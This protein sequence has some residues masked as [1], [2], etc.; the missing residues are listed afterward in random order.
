MSRDS[1]YMI[2]YVDKI[3][4]PVHGFIDI[5]TV[6]QR[7]IALPIFR[8][9]QSIK[10]LSMT[11]WVFPGAEHTRYIHSLGVMYIADQM[12]IHLKGF[13]DEDRQLVRLAGLLHDIGHYPLSHVT[14]TAY[15]EQLMEYDGSLEAH[16]GSVRDKVEKLN[17]CKI[18]EYMESRYTDKMHHENIGATV[19]KTDK[20][21]QSIIN[22]ECPFIDTE[23]IC[24]IIVG[25]VDRNPNNSIFVQ[26][27]HSELDADGIDYIMRDAS[28]SGT[29]Y[30]SFSLGMLLRNLTLGSYKGTQIVGVRPKGVPIADQ[31][32]ISKYLSYTQVI[33]NKHVAILDLMIEKCTHALINHAHS[34]YPSTKDFMKWVKMHNDENDDYLL[35]TDV[36][37]WS[38]VT[39]VS[40]KTDYI[41]EEYVR[42]FVHNLIHYNEPCSID[43]Y[44]ITSG[45]MKKVQDE[46]MKSKPYREL[47]VNNNEILLFHERGFTKEIPEDKYKELLS[48]IWK[49]AERDD[50]FENSNTKRLQEGIA[51]IEGNNEPKLLVDDPRSL[52]YALWKDRT[53]ILRR[54]KCGS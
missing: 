29:S 2:E 35:F 17:E 16:N 36:F 54:Y 52:M 39:D 13:N 20:H 38:Q 42:R 15:R 12:L 30:G 47:N 32:L 49:N 18:P 48:N 25:D 26:L 6:E 33:F 14:E 21:I 34:E 8:R 51:V 40:R 3:L 37:F 45:D 7:L 28:F 50:L 43:E 1:G 46:I 5:T 27:M 24:D 19:I 22:Q 53:F 23:D 9:L 10:Q 11:N 44:V 4:D 31:Y 41:D